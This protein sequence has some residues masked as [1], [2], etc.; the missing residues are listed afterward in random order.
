MLVDQES[1]NSWNQGTQVSHRLSGA[2]QVDAASSVATR[3]MPTAYVPNIG[4]GFESE[5]SSLKR[6]LSHCLL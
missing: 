3:T 6:N 5:G 2:C 4:R 1:K